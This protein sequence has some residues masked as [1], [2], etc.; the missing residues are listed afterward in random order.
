MNLDWNSFFSTI[1][2]SA[3]GMIAIIAAFIISK[4]L[5]ENEK[6][7]SLEGQ[8]DELI[9]DYNDI[10]HRVS[11][12][13]FEWLDKMEID[14]DDDIETAIKAGEFNSLSD[15]DK[16]LKLYEIAPYLHQTDA[17][18]PALK[19]LIAELT[20]RG[21][22]FNQL[23]HRLLRPVEVWYKVNEEHEKVKALQV[24]SY[25]LINKFT[26]LKEDC[27]SA[28]RNL[29]PI[30]NLLYILIIGFLVAAIY[31]LH[32]LPMGENENPSIEFSIAALKCSLFSFKGIFII[33]LTAVV[34]GIFGYFLYF[35]KEIRKGYKSLDDLLATKYLILKNYSPYFK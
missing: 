28:Q 16:L 13:K 19:K 30:Q 2:Q 35:I 25:T 29:K 31:P 34:I 4:L 17:C 5:G 23:S 10:V 6:M 9:I 7:E 18:L 8:I 22:G 3:S 21:F 15:E 32:F 12:R 26:K 33:L 1:S 11:H 20:P 14:R 27:K 24:D